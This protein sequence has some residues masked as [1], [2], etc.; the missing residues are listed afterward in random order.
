MCMLSFPH[1]I[2]PLTPTVHWSYVPYIKLC[3]LYQLRQI[4]LTDRNFKGKFWILGLFVG[5]YQRTQVWS[6]KEDK[7]YVIWLMVQ[8]TPSFI[9]PSHTWSCTVPRTRYHLD[10]WRCHLSE[11][12]SPAFDYMKPAEGWGHDWEQKKQFGGT[13]WSVNSPGA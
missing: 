5:L 9:H 8:V 11:I 12:H 13:C 1:N 3:V 6:W 7:K 10:T 4:Y 2:H